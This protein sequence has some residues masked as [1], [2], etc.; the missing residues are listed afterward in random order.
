MNKNEGRMFVMKFKMKH[1]FNIF[2]VTLLRLQSNYEIKFPLYL[3][4]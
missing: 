1:C 3:H 4:P 2:D